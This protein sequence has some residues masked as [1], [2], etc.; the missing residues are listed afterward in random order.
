MHTHT[1]TQPLH[2]SHQPA[3][4][5]LLTD[6]NPLDPDARSSL[7]I[8]LLKV[9]RQLNIG[10]LIFSPWAELGTCNYLNLCLA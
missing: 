4:L 2:L 1:H 10:L 7:L 9:D 8:K 5:S 6:P 3:W